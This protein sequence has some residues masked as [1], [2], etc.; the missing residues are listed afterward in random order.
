MKSDALCFLAFVL[1]EIPA[2]EIRGFQQYAAEHFDSQRALCSP[3]HITLVAPFQVQSEQI[4][5]LSGTLENFCAQVVPVNIT[6]D[7]FS[8]FGERVI[9]VNV[10]R[11][12][13]LEAIAGNLQKH[14]RASGFSVRTES[15]PFHPHVTVAFKDL[16][17][18]MF[19]KAYAFFQQIPCE[20]TWTAN[21]LTLL[22]HRHGRWQADQ[23]FACGRHIV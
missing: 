18:E 3:P 11:D 17:R 4:P 5:A 1:P 13:A 16:R 14:L 23:T 8:A 7:G 10:V 21:A 12:P 20:V 22:R 9:F 6:L 2:S 15:G 19:G